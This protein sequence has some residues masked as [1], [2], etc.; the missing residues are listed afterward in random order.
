MNIQN[1]PFDLEEV[2]K[3]ITQFANL[4]LSQGARQ[5]A[6]TLNTAQFSLNNN[7]VVIE[8]HNEAQR[9]Q[10]TSIKQE[11][12]DELRR[13]LKNSGVNIDLHLNK[14]DSKVK[15]YKPTDIFKAMAE[16][17]PSLIELKKRFDLEIDY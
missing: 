15:A 6:N 12:V 5:L 16:K 3:A 17:N 13:S 4:K 2:K 14:E 7:V 9:E 10:L 11:F 8:L 1:T